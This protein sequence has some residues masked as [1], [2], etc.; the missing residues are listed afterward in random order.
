MVIFYDAIYMISE[1]N[2]CIKDSIKL[3]LMDRELYNN[4]NK[5]F[6]N[7]PKITKKN[8]KMILKY[9][10]KKF[11]LDKNILIRN[12]NLYYQKINQYI[13]R[14][15]IDLNTIPKNI[16]K[17]IID[18]MEDIDIINL[19]ELQITSIDINKIDYCNI[20]LPNC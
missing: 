8:H 3:S 4:S 6:L 12:P 5:I 7:C 10:L 13:V 14:D 20:L 17:L 2:N 1:Y 19:K 18:L 15:N 11:E 9:N 16:N